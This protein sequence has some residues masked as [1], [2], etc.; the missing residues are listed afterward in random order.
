MR[1]RLSFGLALALLI[2]LAAAFVAGCPKAQPPPPPIQP[3]AAPPP[4]M[5]TEQPS[6]I[7]GAA[8][9]G[10]PEKATPETKAPET[11][12]GLK[13]TEPKAGGKMPAAK[14]EGKIATTASGLKY[15]DVKVGSGPMPRK[16][17]VVVVHYTGWLK[18]GTKF[19]SSRDKGEP[20][21]FTLGAHEV[22]PGWDEGLATMKV[23]G[24][25]TLFVPP[26]LGYRERGTPDGAI[27]PNAELKFDVELLGVK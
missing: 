12:A 24:R 13:P 15:T 22:I 5:P 10:E 23:G 7:T 3:S 11:K 9:P 25:R 19:D 4:V 18:D 8:K 14:P 2:A 26:K 1:T 20:F 21:Q 27:P 16:G 6:E 17:Q